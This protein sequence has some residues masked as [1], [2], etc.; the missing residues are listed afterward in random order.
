MP[1]DKPKTEQVLGRY[2]MLWDCEYC[3]AT[4]LLALTHR[5]C[6]SCGAKQGEAKRYFP[7][8][9]DKVAVTDEYAGTDKICPSCEHANGAKATFCANCGAGL[10]DAAAAKKRSEQVAK[11]GHRFDADDAKKA[12]ADLSGAKKPMAKK[13]SSK[14]WIYILIVVAVAIFAI[15]FLCIRS[16]TIELEVAE[17]RWTKAIPI[18]E[19]RDVEKEGWKH[20]MPSRARVTSCRDEQY[21]SKKVQDGEDC[22][23]RR[24]DK[25]DGTFEERQECTPRYKSE[26]VTRPKCKYF[27]EEWVVRDTK[28]SVATDGKEPSWPDTGVT[29]G[30]RQR[31]GD[32]KEIFEVVLAKDGKTVKTCAVKKRTWDD[33]NKGVTVVAEETKAGGIGCDSIKAK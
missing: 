9:G 19:Y 2:E 7:E 6:P 25:G 27:V 22:Q 8:D 33:L 29:P 11:A 23:T 12:A 26:G 5:H 13:R 18:E 1:D 3:G 31:E 20:E 16:K 10:D 30:P 15:W 14:A 24:V 21:E 28:A 32:R 17:R 4:K